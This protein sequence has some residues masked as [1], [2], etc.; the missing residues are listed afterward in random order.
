MSKSK[1]TD[2]TTE[3]FDRILVNEL[4]TYTADGILAIPGIY[5]IL[6]EYFNN[7]VLEAWELEHEI[8]ETEL[9]E[10]EL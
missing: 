6:S 7:E 10:P 1:Y 9:A 3:D 8:G 5:E 2:L 4:D